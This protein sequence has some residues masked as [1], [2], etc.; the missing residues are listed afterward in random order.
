MKTA[1]G[2]IVAI[3]ASCIAWSAHAQAA[4]TGKQTF[5]HWCGACH[6]EGPRMPGTSALQAKYTGEK[7]A[8]LERRTDLTPELVKFFVRKGVS[9]M[10][11]FRKTE[12]TDAELDGLADY[13]SHAPAAH[14]K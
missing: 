9:V 6:A 2:P 14:K 5:D 1:F 10:P 7:P 4:A 13:L 11:P 8:A 3:A 12:I